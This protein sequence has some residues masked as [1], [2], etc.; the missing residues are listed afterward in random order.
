MPV[1][2]PEGRALDKPAAAVAVLVMTTFVAGMMLGGTD[3]LT[4]PRIARL[5]K[6]E[7]DKAARDAMGL[8]PGA[9]LKEERTR[10]ANGEIVD[11][12]G[13]D[14]GSVVGRTY[15]VRANGYGGPVQAL[16]AV[17]QAGTILRAV[18]VQHTETP[19]L[20]AKAGLPEFLDQFKG[21]KLDDPML[22]LRKLGGG[23]DAVTGATISSSA[24]LTA[25]REALALESRRVKAGGANGA[26][27]GASSDE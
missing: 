5:I 7:Q 14:G 4:R 6:A 21:K 25:V 8:G 12:A 9:A 23:I 20:G 3:A 27:P 24:V 19:G 22:G 17:D 26:Q 16:V 11:T 15:L 13:L 2:S 1:P 18:V 10:D